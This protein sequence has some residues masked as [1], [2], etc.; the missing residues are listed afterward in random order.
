M[1]EIL[2]KVS[3]LIEKSNNIPVEIKPIVKAICRGYIRESNCKISV[4]GIIN[5]CNTVFEKVDEDDYSF[6]GEERIFG[7]TNTDYDDNCNI[8]HKMQYINDPNY[9]KLITILTHELGHVITEPRPCEISADGL[10]PIIKRTTTF[11]LKCKY[12]DNKLYAYNV[13]GH[14]MSDGFLESICT[15]IFASNEFREELLHSGYDLKDYIYKDER[16]FPSRVYDEYKACFELFDYIMNGTLFDFSCTF[17]DTNKDLINYVN[18]YKLNLLFQ[19]L[20]KSN[21]ALWTLKTYEGKERNEEFGKL[22]DKYLEEK[23]MSLEVSK[24]FLEAYG[25]KED[26]EK[27]QQLYGIYSSMLEKQRLLPIPDEYLNSEEKQIS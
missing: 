6:T 12:Q 27:F 1:D 7:Y 13:F 11:Y 14:R 22:L 25:K 8:I 4:D 21:E 20:D 3:E 24:V 10:Y 18:K 2:N 23:N 26:D 17:F 9:I 15:K 19:Y 16:L 5:V